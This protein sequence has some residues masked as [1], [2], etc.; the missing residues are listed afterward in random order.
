MAYNVNIMTTFQ[1]KEVK[2]SVFC[3]LLH[4][5][6]ERGEPLA[7]IQP[8]HIQPKDI[9]P[10]DIQP[11]GYPAEWTSSRLDIQPT[12]RPA[13]SDIQPKDIQPTDIQPTQTSSRLDIQPT[14]HPADWTSS[15]LDIQPTRTS[16]QLGHPADSDI[17][18]T[19][20]LFFL[21]PWGP[22]YTVSDHAIPCYTM[23]YHVIPCYT[24]SYHVIP[25][26]TMP[27]HAPSKTNRDTSAPGSE[28]PHYCPQCAATFCARPMTNPP[29][30]VR[31]I[32]IFAQRW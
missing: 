20:Y 12:G 25:Y 18:L 26:Y 15:R 5:F 22:C 30:C 11:T 31:Q 9:Q 32:W 2:K 24:M 7:D 27:Y 23:L 13:D 3:T 16:S 14:G 19:W 29:Q 17:Q 21:G 1:K 6:A 10:T 8:T 4:F 28:L